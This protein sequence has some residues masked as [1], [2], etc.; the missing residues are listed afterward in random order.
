MRKG[1][2]AVHTRAYYQW[3]WRECTRARVY[4]AVAPAVSARTATTRSIFGVGG[5]EGCARDEISCGVSS[6]INFGGA[7][8]QNV[9]SKVT[10]GGC[11]F[12]PRTCERCTSA[13]IKRAHCC[14][15]TNEGEQ[16]HRKGGQAGTGRERECDG[17]GARARARGGAGR[18]HLPRRGSAVCVSIHRAHRP[19][20]SNT[21][22]AL[23]EARAADTRARAHLLREGTTTLLCPRPPPARGHT[24][25][26]PHFSSLQER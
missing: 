5:C 25:T 21:R 2:A 6:L 16:Q 1:G 9:S 8:R 4:S 13:S 22:P 24:T 14:T 15:P 26:T 18:A 23:S 7:T 10:G 3:R 12:I 19:T 11:K 20:L 17:G